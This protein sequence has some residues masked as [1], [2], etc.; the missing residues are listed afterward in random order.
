[1]VTVAPGTEFQMIVNL[2]A[3]EGAAL[4]V[5][6]LQLNFANS[7]IGNGELVLKDWILKKG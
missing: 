2:D 1:M 7:S 6:S 4:E 3:S 5:D